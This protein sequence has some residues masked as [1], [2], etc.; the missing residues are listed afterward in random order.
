MKVEFNPRWGYREDGLVLYT[1]SQSRL[2]HQSSRL[3]AVASNRIS[4][5]RILLIC[6]PQL[7][8]ECQPPGRRQHAELSA[9]SMCSHVML[10]ECQK[11]IRVLRDKM[12]GESYQRQLDDRMRGCKYLQCH[13]DYP[14][15]LFINMSTSGSESEFTSNVSGR[16]QASGIS[17]LENHEIFQDI[18]LMGKR[19]Q[20]Q[21]RRGT[22]KTSQRRVHPVRVHQ[23]Q[24]G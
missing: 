13:R 19:S 11:R 5:S 2:H 1:F 14:P 20:T 9:L 15:A 6:G 18:H 7:D 3:T 4:K 8:R 10:P 17:S 24:R 21:R 22:R 12:Q 23:S 16:R